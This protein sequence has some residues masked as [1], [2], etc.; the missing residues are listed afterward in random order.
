MLRDGNSHSRRI[1]R[2][3]LD[4]PMIR[5]GGRKDGER[6]D[7]YAR[8]DDHVGKRYR[9]SSAKFNKVATIVGYYFSRPRLVSCPKNSFNKSFVLY[10][11]AGENR[12]PVRAGFKPALTADSGSRRPGLRRGCPE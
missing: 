3:L 5:A 2:D 12:H 10:R 9:F 6:L 11:H 4:E 8:V 7:D 1:T